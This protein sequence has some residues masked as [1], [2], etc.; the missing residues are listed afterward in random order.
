M[1]LSRRPD[2]VHQGGLWEFPGGKVEAGEEVMAALNRELAEELGLQCL[3]ARPLITVHHHYADK[4]VWLDVWCV[5]RWTGQPTGREGQPLRWVAPDALPDVEMPAADVPIINA[6]RLPSRYLVTPEPTGDDAAF[7][8]ELA[9]SLNSGAR[10]VQLRAKA[11]PAT[12][13]AS[14]ARKVIVATR[15]HGGQLLL[16]AEPSL[17][18]ALGADGVHL[19]GERL[20]RCQQRP[21]PRHMWVGV[22]CHNR[23]DLEQAVRIHADFAVLGPVQETRSHAGAVTLGWQ[24]FATL[25]RS[26]GL[27]VYA[28]GGMRPPADEQHAWQAGGQGI[29]AISG[30]WAFR[31]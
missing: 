26:A 5:E 11:L 20:H 29:A 14:L 13:Y 25:V 31:D 22:S 27:P 21:L 15:N 23:N 19:S 30:L 3:A 7:L 1:L 16:N 10:L 8:D 6:I 9:A 24:G 4:Q 17:A 18:L 12:R 28:I 2:H